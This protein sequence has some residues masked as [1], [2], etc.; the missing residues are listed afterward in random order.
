MDAMLLNQFL[1]QQQ[2]LL[3]LMQ[4]MCKKKIVQNSRSNAVQNKVV[5]TALLPNF[6]TFDITKETYK[7]YIQKFKNVQNVEYEGYGVYKVV[8]VY[9]NSSEQKKR[10]R[11]VLC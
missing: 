7:N 1:Q 2:S 10:Y 9:Q 3:V 4:R 5:N 6:E 11:T 8:N